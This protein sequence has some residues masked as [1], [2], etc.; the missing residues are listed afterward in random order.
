MREFVTVPWI[1]H[2]GDVFTIESAHDAAKK[3]NEWG[4]KCAVAGL[5]FT[6]D[7][8]LPER[9]FRETGPVTLTFTLNG[10]LL[11]R[12]RFEQAGQLHYSHDVPPAL[13]RKNAVKRR[14]LRVVA[15]SAKR[16]N[17]GHKS[18]KKV[19]CSAYSL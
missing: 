18:S 17:Q 2:T 3:F 1:P 15:I 14:N 12:A 11:D 9:T 13:L 5:K 19:F 4:Q 8:S 7:F 6:M 16:I 10:K